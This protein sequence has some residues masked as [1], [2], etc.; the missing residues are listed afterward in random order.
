MLYLAASPGLCRFS[1]GN[2]YIV[3]TIV[4]SLSG[5]INDVSHK[6]SP[7][8]LCANTITV[9]RSVA[10][11][12]TVLVWTFELAQAA[13]LVWSLGNRPEESELLWNCVAYGLGIFTL[14]TEGVMMWSIP[15]YSP[16]LLYTAIGTRA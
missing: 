11:A 3:V 14:G 1:I 7:S 13:L 15:G 6:T 9:S 4:F 2:A 16:Q 8:S 12:Y 10:V 5:S